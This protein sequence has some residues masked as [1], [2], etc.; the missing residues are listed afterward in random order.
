MLKP[1]PGQHYF[2]YQPMGWK[3]YENHP[4]SLASWTATEMPDSSRSSSSEIATANDKDLQVTISIPT[5]AQNPSTT[6]DALTFYARPYGSWTQRL[7]NEC[8]KSP[9]GSINPTILLEG[10]YGHQSP[11]HRHEN[12]LLI[13]GGAGITAALPYIHDHIL[14]KQTDSTKTRQL[15]LVWT[16][17]QPAMIHTIAQRE[18]RHALAHSDMDFHFFATGKPLAT[19]AQKDVSEQQHRDSETAPQIAYGRPDIPSTIYNAVD[20][21]AEAGTIGGGIAVLCCGPAAMADEARATVAEAMRRKKVSA[22]Y[23]EE[24]FGW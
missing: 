17:K 9:T 5:D 4:L 12:V 16:T 2:L 1:E 18:L 19:T 20:S 13:V 11:L 10:P 7:R 21:V 23:F 15:T 3:G 14:R 24:A 22:A 6:H 8:L